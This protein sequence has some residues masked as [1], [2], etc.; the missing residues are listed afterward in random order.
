M[1]KSLWLHDCSLPGSS[2]HGIFQA[3]I[4]V[5]VAICYTRESFW[6]RHRTWISCISS[7]DRQ[8]LYHC[9]TWENKWTIRCLDWVGRRRRGW[10]RIRWL[11]SII[12]SVNMSLSKL[13]EIVKDNEAWHAE[14]HGVGKSWTPLSN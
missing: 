10:Q 11:D 14:V 13:R 7:I 4:L 2:V 9:V 6:P 5:G 1:S 3:R 8:I 12:E